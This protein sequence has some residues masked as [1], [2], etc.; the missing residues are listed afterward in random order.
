MNIAGWLVHSVTRK[1]RT[2]TG[3]KGD[4]TYGG[5]TT[6]AARIEKTIKQVRTVDGRVLTTAWRMVTLEPIRVDDKFWLPSIAGESA[7]D[8]ANDNASRSPLQIAT[9]TDKVGRTSH[10]ECYF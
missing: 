5:A 1:Q 10:W 3:S 6:V 2:G 7:D 9:A 8:T 4:P